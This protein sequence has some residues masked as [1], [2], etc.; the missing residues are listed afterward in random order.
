M[1]RSSSHTCK[2]VVG[3]D[4]SQLYPYAICQPMPTGLYTLWEFHADLQRFKHQSNETR[5]FEIMVMAF[6]RIGDR[7]ATLRAFTQ[8]EPSERLTPLAFMGFAVTLKHFLKLSVASI[9]FAN[10]RKCNVVL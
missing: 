2:S 6:F 10:V 7:N 5:S 1:I 8:P 4:S 9:S 3:I